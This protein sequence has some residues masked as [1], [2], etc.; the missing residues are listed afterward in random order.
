MTY[1]YI[2]AIHTYTHAIYVHSDISLIHSYTCNTCTWSHAYIYI[3]Y[4]IHIYMQYEYIPTH[5]DTCHTGAYQRYMHIDA[6]TA[7][8]YMHI[9]AIHSHSS[10]HAHTCTHMY[11]HVHTCTYMQSPNTL[12]PIIVLRRAK[13]PI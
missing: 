5:H 6:C 4:I 2:H 7:C 3:L 10:I 13:E 9:H 1:L 11:I 12:Q 8:I